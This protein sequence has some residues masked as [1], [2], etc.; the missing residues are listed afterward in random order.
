M[1]KL[2][3]AGLVLLD[4][5]NELAPRLLP[6][7][8]ADCPTASTRPVWLKESILLLESMV[9]TA[10]HETVGD[11]G[12]FKLPKAI[13]TGLVAEMP[14]CELLM[15]IERVPFASVVP[16]GLICCPDPVLV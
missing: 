7:I 6:V 16:T 12:P 10:G 15:V 11:C 3:I 14:Y 9:A 5:Y 4:R 1:L 2:A 13:C 8:V